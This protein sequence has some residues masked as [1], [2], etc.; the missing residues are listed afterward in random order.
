M[1]YR[2]IEELDKLVEASK[3]PIILKSGVINVEDVEKN[4]QMESII[5][6]ED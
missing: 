1:N 6:E 3:Q 4:H 2:R 5:K